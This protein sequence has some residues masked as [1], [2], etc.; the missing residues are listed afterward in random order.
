MSAG[1]GE[2]GD[3]EGGSVSAAAVTGVGLAQPG[4]QR[5]ARVAFS[6]RS[7]ASRP[8]THII[9]DNTVRR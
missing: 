6:A 3:R 1:G 5:A 8:L 7:P 4:R 2:D 9:A